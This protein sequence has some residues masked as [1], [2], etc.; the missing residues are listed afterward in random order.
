MRLL[1]DTHVLLWAAANPNKLPASF[2]SRLESVESTVLFSA[3]SIWE[4]AIKV[5]LGKLELAVAP[6][7]FAGTA[8]ERGFEELP[9]TAAHAAAA[10]RLPL[11]HRDP[12]DRILVAQAI[13]EPARLLTLDRALAPYSELVEVGV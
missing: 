11:L 10:G 13:L 12:F 7:D 4:I 2:R 3:A 5:Q 8:V 9:I 6:E 1:V